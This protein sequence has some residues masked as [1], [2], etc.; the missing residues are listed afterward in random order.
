MANTDERLLEPSTEAGPVTP[1]AVRAGTTAGSP[2]A[3]AGQ[4]V[5]AEPHPAAR[6]SPP[7]GPVPLLPENR[8]PSHPLRKWL[9][10]AAVVV[11]LAVGAYFLVPWV[12]TALNTVAT[13][14]AY[15]NGPVTFVAPRVA[16][17]VATVLVDDNDRLKKGDLLVQLDR[18]AAE[19]SE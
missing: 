1:Y 7:P 10:L 16:G 11:G 4:A 2:G 8:P 15:V 14:D 6:T 18:K 12:T 9:I 3:A 17:E 19:G 13:D 5:P